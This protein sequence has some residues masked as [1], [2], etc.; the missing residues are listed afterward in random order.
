MVVKFK[1]STLDQKGQAFFEMIMFVPFMIFLFSLIVTF[2]NSVNGA[3]NQNKITRGFFFATTRN[4]SYGMNSNDL[5]LLKDR[6]VSITGL[7]VIGYRGKKEG[8]VSYGACYRINRF[9]GGKK[10]EECTDAI[11]GANESSYVRLFTF[12]GVC[13][14]AWKFSSPV[15]QPQAE[16]TGNS[17]VECRNQP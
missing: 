7:H 16:P 8:E 17:I 1:K 2:G 5:T 9:F 15:I 6:G 14:Q 10:E 13:A 11:N 12:Y 3:I 4:N